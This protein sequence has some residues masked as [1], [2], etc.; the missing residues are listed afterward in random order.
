MSALVYPDSIHYTHKHIWLREEA[1]G[2]ATLGITD[3]AQDQ[4]GEIAFLDLPAIG[5]TFTQGEEFG[6]VESIKSVNALYMPVSG[7]VF[8]VNAELSSTPTQVNMEPYGSGWM[9]QIQMAPNATRNELISAAEYEAG[10]K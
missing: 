4:L 5:K 3:F 2:I 9:L 10:L 1:N 7:T 6:T 8:H